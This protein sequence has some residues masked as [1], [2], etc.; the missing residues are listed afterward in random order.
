MEY[1]HHIKFSCFASRIHKAMNK[2][3]KYKEHCDNYKCDEHAEFE[4]PTPL[5]LGYVELDEDDAV[6]DQCDED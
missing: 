1:I 3:S 6:G 5:V 4:P 2:E